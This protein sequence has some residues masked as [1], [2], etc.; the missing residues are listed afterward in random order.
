MEVPREAG[1]EWE[2]Q[3]I[4]A[5]R[6]QHVRSAEMCEWAGLRRGLGL[7]GRM[8]RKSFL[9]NAVGEV[10]VGP[11]DPGTLSSCFLQADT[12]EQENKEGD[13]RGP[14]VPSGPA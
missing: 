12:W 1:Q 8:Q 3:R 5:P 14:G 6:G 4:R 10:P 11:G 9:H 2:V 7:P 13:R